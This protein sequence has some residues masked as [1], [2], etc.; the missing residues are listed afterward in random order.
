MSDKKTKM[1]CQLSVSGTDAA[2]AKAAKDMDIPDPTPAVGKQLIEDATEDD[3]EGVNDG[4]Q[5][6][7]IG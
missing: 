4:D 1:D 2:N 3:E 5:Q 6:E 7:N